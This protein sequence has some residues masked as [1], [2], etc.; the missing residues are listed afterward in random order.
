M[1]MLC[2]CLTGCATIINGSDQEIGVSS[3]P[4]G[5]QVTVNNRRKTTTPDTVHLQRNENHIM[6]FELEGYE[7]GSATVTNSASGWMWGNIVFGGLIGLVVDLVS[8]GGRK[9][10]P[11]T[12]HVDLKPIARPIAKLEPA[13]GAMP[14]QPAAVHAQ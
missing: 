3:N 7:P 6:L 12:V 8:G 2:A 4:A 5:A 10:S 11:Q 9:L 13:P 14:L 1:L